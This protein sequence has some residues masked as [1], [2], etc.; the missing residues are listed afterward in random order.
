MAD[1]K[2]PATSPLSEVT[3]DAARAI[4]RLSR[5]LEVALAEVDLTLSQYRVLVFLANGESRPSRIAPNVNVTRPTVTALVDGLVTRGLVDRQPDDHDRRRVRH[6]VTAA[7][8]RA[9]AEADRAVDAHLRVLSGYLD[10]KCASDALRGL[11]VWHGAM[12]AAIAAVNPADAETGRGVTHANTPR[13][14]VAR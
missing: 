8:K 9:L 5:R 7:G 1:R 14:E 3:V 13:R 6:K 2:K 4:V 11:A 10:E 12:D